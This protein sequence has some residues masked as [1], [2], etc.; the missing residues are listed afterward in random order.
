MG[1]LLIVG[2]LTFS[3]LLTLLIV[4][5][6]FSLA[7]GIE[8]RIGPWMRQR[9]LSLTRTHKHPTIAIPSETTISNRRRQVTRKLLK[10]LPVRGGDPYE[11]AARCAFGRCAAD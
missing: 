10:G 7:D 2:A 11:P 3:T 5:A 1:G 6:G 4:P 9:L 8:K